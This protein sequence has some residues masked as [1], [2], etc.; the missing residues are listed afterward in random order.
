MPCEIEVRRAIELMQIEVVEEPTVDHKEKYDRNITK[1]VRKGFQLADIKN[2]IKSYIQFRSKLNKITDKLI[3][4]LPKSLKDIDFK[5][6]LF[7]EYTLTNETKQF[8]RYDNLN[9]ARRIITQCK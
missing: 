3:P 6:Q 7:K 8:L 9:S 1:V 4:T 5:N 2:S